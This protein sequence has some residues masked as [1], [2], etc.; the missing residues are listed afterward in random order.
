MVVYL[1]IFAIAVVAAFLLMPLARAMAPRLGALDIPGNLA[2]HTHPVPRTGGLAIFGGFLV[3]AGYAWW[4]GALPA[5]QS[6]LLLGVLAGGALI[7]LTGLLDDAR[8][9]S[10]APKFAGQVLAAAVAI[11]LG[12]QTRFLPVAGLSLVLTI[13][14]LIGSANAMNLLDGMDGLAGGTTVI[15][16]LSLGLIAAIQGNGLVI[17]LALAL[18]GAT[19]GFLPFNFPRGRIFMGDAGSLSLGFTLATMGLLLADRPYDPLRFAVSLAVLGVPILDTA[20]ALARRFLRRTDPFGGDRDHV[21]DV[22]ARRWGERRAVGAVW[23]SSAFLGGAAAAAAWLGGWAGMGLILLAA[24]VVLGLARRSGVLAPL[25]TRGHHDGDGSDEAPAQSW[26]RRWRL[27]LLD[28]AIVAVGYY[29][30]LGLRFSGWMPAELAQMLRYGRALTSRIALIA[31]AY[32]GAGL[33]FG[34]YDC[35]WQYASS[36]EALTILVAGG[37]VTLGELIVQLLQ[38]AKRPLPLSVVLMGGMLTTAGFVAVRYRQRLISGALWRLGVEVDTTRQRVLIAG[39]GEAGQLLA[40]QMRH[41]EGQL[42][43]V[44]FVDDDPAKMGLSV[45]GVRV[46]GTLADIPRLV[47]RHRIELVVIAI[48]RLS[49]E[50]LNE[51][52]DL[53][54]GTDARVQILPDVVAEL[55]ASKGLA[56]PRMLTLDD[57]LGRPPREIDQAACRS[58][59]SGR[60]VLVTGAAGSIGSELCRQVARHGP[61][62]LLALDQD[63][64][65][66]FNLNL[67]LREDGVLIVDDDLLHLLVGDVSDEERM[68]VIWRD[69]R[70]DIV[71]HCAAY[72]HVP[73]LESCPGQAVRANVLG[74]L[75]PAR[76]SRLWG[77]ERFIL[78]STDK[79]ACP[80]NVMGASKR[81]A[82]LLVLALQDAADVAPGTPGPHS[83]SPGPGEPTMFAEVRFG[84]VL[85]SR[86]SVVP[87]ISRQIDHGGPVTITDPRMKRFFMS[88]PEAVS[89]VIQAGAYTTGGDLFV[90]DMGE[91]VRIEDLARKM[92]RLRGLRPGSDIPI[93]VVGIRPGE[94]LS[95]ILFCPVLEKL[96]ATS[97]PAIM[98]V[99]NQVDL[100]CEALFTNVDRMIAR[101]GDDGDGEVRRLLFETARLL[102]PEDCADYESTQR[103]E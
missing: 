39:A 13:F 82:E 5:E 9:I 86:G 17:V 55:G 89:L 51:V 46:L 64:T 4:S 77:T 28:L 38:G 41:H 66:L 68:A 57:L 1:V 32:V 12:V 83:A 20:L 61:A 47:S 101:A 6:S 19:L 42:S 29:M 73:L 25:A 58:L 63:E 33:V 78:V 15:A 88:I 50:R 98:R 11:G 3:A 103:Y 74:T 75:I 90:L 92:I 65:G 69:H 60:V 23:G 100:P 93:E 22:L 2:I 99:R 31:L 81:V 43:P 45:H 40:W 85:G 30:A 49:R 36:E 14:Y 102:C 35:I 34:L 79:A 44:G 54:Q 53:C 56:A 52:F 95:E 48:L 8:H 18:A 37:T 87:T 97:H 62:R 27:V 76:L 84:N 70:P 80:I 94:K 26:R 91:P 72:K 16:A 67:R 96:E 10:P 7:A 24:V 71:F 59:I 21:Y